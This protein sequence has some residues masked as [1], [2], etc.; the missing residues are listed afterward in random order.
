MILQ[1][2]RIEVRTPESTLI[3]ANERIC[4]QVIYR[5]NGFVCENLPKNVLS[6]I[7]FR[8][9]LSDHGPIKKLT[10]AGM[11]LSKTARAIKI[12]DAYSSNSCSKTYK[13][14]Y[15]KI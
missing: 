1:L 2:L 13:S 10:N 7:G 15:F 12:F 9:N 5:D 6:K 4:D 8:P 3:E 14:K 11:M